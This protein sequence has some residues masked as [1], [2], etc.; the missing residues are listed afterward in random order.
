MVW[1]GEKI[2][3]YLI[4]VSKGEEQK[5]EKKIE[6]I[7]VLLDLSGMGVSSFKWSLLNS[8]NY[9]LTEDQEV[10]IFPTTVT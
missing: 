6:E 8:R 3:T 2:N 5:R 7:L 9:P 10:L 1:H 4:E